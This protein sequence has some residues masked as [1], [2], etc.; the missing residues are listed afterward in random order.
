MMKFIFVLF[1]LSPL[2][3]FAQP[4]LQGRIFIK[5]SPDL[6]SGVNIRN[7]TQGFTNQSD[8]GGNFRVAAAIGDTVLF[9]SAGY[10]GDTV[11]VDAASLQ[12]QHDVDLS[13][14]VTTLAS[15]E[16]DAMS[17]FVADSLQ[18]RKDYAEFYNKKHPVK[19][20]NEKREMD[21]AG[22]SF[23]PIGY[24]SNAEKQK[25]RFR[26]RLKEEEESQFVSVRFP[27]SRVAQL[28][29]LTG[30]S[31][32]HFMQLYTPSYAWCRKATNQ[33]V[34]LWI[35]DKMILFRSGAAKG[36]GKHG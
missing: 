25:R 4:Y 23:S 26:K 14:L 33:D 8:Q 29:R 2:F 24:N 20:W 34:L 1:F 17:K 22:L 10:K 7:K 35:N 36:S 19:M 18:R 6:V 11:F 27:R 3:S 28:T 9:S 12:L 32:Q 15:V 31:L 21:D 16:V 30:D 13:P 5:G